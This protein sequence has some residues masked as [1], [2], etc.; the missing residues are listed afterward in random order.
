TATALEIVL[1]CAI[2]ADFYGA[3]VRAPQWAAALGSPAFD[4]RVLTSTPIGTGACLL[5]APLILLVATGAGWIGRMLARPL[6]VLLGEASY[7]LY[8]IQNVML[9]PVIRDPHWLEAWS[10]AGRTTRSEERRV[11]K[12]G[13]YRWSR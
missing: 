1:L 6:P 2:A 13:R 5:Y 7:A 4:W 12:E 9:I 10:A 8:M 11:G 3:G